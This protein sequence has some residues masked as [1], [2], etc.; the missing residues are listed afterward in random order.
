MPK[1]DILPKGTRKIF[2]T[3]ICFKL[4]PDY[5]EISGRSWVTAQ[6]IDVKLGRVDPDSYDSVKIIAE[7]KSDRDFPI[8]KGVAI[9]HMIVKEFIGGTVQ[10]CGPNKPD[11]TK[12][13]FTGE[14]KHLGFGSTTFPHT[15]IPLLSGEDPFKK[16][17][18]PK[19]SPYTLQKKGS[20]E[21][22][23]KAAF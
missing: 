17:E 20:Y 2:D 14:S 7:N 16:P 19:T 9:A 4:D 6:G 1:D 11:L 18:V 23:E 22:L 21:H 13:G 15:D 10:W 5:G 12:P 8:E 3:L